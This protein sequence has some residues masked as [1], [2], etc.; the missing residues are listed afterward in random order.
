MSWRDFK[1]KVK[2]FFDGTEGEAGTD[3]PVRHAERLDE[4]AAD[5]PR[6]VPAVDII[7]SAQE[8]V[9]TADVP[10]AVRDHT[11]VL[12]DGTQT[13]VIQAGVQG[14]GDNRALISER[15][16]GDWYRVF[17][18]PSYL[19]GSKATS[20]LVD[21]VLTVRIPRRKGARPKLI[22]VRRSA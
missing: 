12:F 16:E 13:L 11:N 3:L 21:G 5:R 14:V 22:P 6:L 15:R 1:D 9:L 8:L 17:Q 2:Q 7:E 20:G 19:D 4:P 18:I 10:G